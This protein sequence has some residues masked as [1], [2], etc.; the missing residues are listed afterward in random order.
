MN[1]DDKIIVDDEV[2]IKYDEN[3]NSNST[4][5]AQNY[6]YSNTN[7]RKS[8]FFSIAFSKRYVAL[9]LA[10]LSVLFSLFMKFL[11]CCGV[12]SFAF[13]GIW[14]FI[15][16]SFAGVS[17]VMNI[18]N[19]AKNKKVDFNVSSIICFLAIIILFLI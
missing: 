7:I 2:E 18:V 15:S 9:T 19:Y 8:N 11:M 12:I 6:N 1:L 3:A 17:L 16:A 13:Y 14:F 4:N 10:T 5:Q